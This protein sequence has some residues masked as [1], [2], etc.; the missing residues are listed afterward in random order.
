[1]RHRLYNLWEATVVLRVV[2]SS[3]GSSLPISVG[4]IP[5]LSADRDYL[6]RVTVGASSPGQTTVTVV[7]DEP[8][9]LKISSD[10]YQEQSILISQ[11]TAGEA[12]MK[13][14]KNE[15]K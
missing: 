11:G 14:K 15:I 6:P 2:D 10:G 5:G 4:P 13:L 3:T 7:S 1:L 9:N 12:V 8:F